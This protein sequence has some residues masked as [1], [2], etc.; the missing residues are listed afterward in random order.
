D[1]VETH[2]KS[3]ISR[4]NK[5]RPADQPRL[6]RRRNKKENESAR[7]DKLRNNHDWPIA[8]LVDQ[9]PSPRSNCQLPG[10]HH[11]LQCLP[12]LILKFEHANRKRLL[13]R[14]RESIGKRKPE[15]ELQQSS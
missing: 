13:R 1:I 2:I 11:S 5:E 6:L 15:E 4:P 10:T 12:K 14:C 7:D 8:K 9:S 3:R